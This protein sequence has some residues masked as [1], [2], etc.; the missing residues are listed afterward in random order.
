MRNVVMSGLS[1]ATV[2]VEAG[3][4]SGARMQARVALQHGRTVFLL[5]SLV[6]EHEWAAKYVEEGAHGTRAI[7]IN[8]TSDITGRLNAMR[9]IPAL[10]I[11]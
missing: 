8:S 6:E 5:K 9:E 7:L 10:A 2:V 1:Q 3:E 4:T 11:A